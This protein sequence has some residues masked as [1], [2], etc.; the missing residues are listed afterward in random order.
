MSSTGES[1]T[2]ESAA[3][4]V[5]EREPPADSGRAN[6]SDGEEVAA[7]SHATSNEPVEPAEQ[8]AGIGEGRADDPRL[9]ALVYGIA[10]LPFAVAAIAL[11][12][13]GHGT[14]I[15]TADHA[16]IEARTI[17][18]AQRPPLVGLY[19][20]ADWA[21][22]GPLMFYV[23][24][25]FHWA[26]GGS[27]IATHLG[28][29]AINGGSVF[30]MAVLARRRGGLP[31][32]L[33]TLVATGLLM[34]TLG[35]EFLHDPWNTYLPVLPFALL[36]FLAW[37]M[38]CGDRW[39]LPVGVVVASFAAQTHV[40]FV[41]L[42]LPLL[43][44]G[45]F[46][47]GVTTLRNRSPDP[48]RAETSPEVEAVRRSGGDDHQGGDPPEGD[49]PETSEASERSLSWRD[50]LSP[51]ALPTLA[52][53][54]LGLA[55]W[56]PPLVDVVR[57]TPSNAQRI[58]R[59]FSD[60]EGGLHS[61][62]DGIAVI[63]GQ[64]SLPAEWLMYKQTMTVSGESPFLDDQFRVPWLILPVVVAALYLLWKGS[65]DKRHLVAV[66]G[67]TFVLGIVGVWRTVGPA[68]DYRLRWTWVPPMVAFVM[69]AWAGWSALA[70]WRP[71][72]TARWLTAAAVGILVVLSSV[73]AV[74]AARGGNPYEAD[75]EVVGTVGEQVLDSL[76]DGD[77]V[78]Y[79]KEP[80]HHAAWY[81]RGLVL[82]LERRGVDV[83]VEEALVLHFG[84]H[85]VYDGEPILATLTVM[86]DDGIDVLSGQ[87]DLSVAGAWESE[88]AHLWEAQRDEREELNR[89]YDAKE[90]DEEEYMFRSRQLTVPEIEAIH[91]RVTVFLD[92]SEVAGA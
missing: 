40:G 34:R 65:A 23:L 39:A 70:R 88:H 14:H 58:V 33:I 73:N 72:G 54:A 18:V 13:S 61:V 50:R 9:V 20:R 68:F 3:A 51:L 41:A 56:L 32:L 16:M 59:W 78:V 37:S 38:A 29:L 42:G 21:H 12:V 81:S 83:R 80:Y 76:P 24:A 84:A 22:P 43:A 52:A 67:L 15:P 57:N 69:V 71:A 75:T 11:W 60:G 53:G 35:A 86:V 48:G 77:G 62:S 31:L 8:T 36:A 1:T 74:T 82:Y 85:R 30:G 19:S 64:F 63:V 6:G 10:L 87:P 7:S 5:E 26:T 90:I 47:L 46:W 44:W 91:Y 4:D 89:A 27:S 55:V 45:A 2:G 49:R 25:P 79:V 92:E 28:A 17:D 66:A